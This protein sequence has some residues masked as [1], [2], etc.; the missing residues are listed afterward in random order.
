MYIIGG[1]MYLE[2]KLFSDNLLLHTRP[3]QSI[4]CQHLLVIE[5]LDTRGMSYISEAI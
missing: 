4:D 2:E 5:L 1:W 3:Y